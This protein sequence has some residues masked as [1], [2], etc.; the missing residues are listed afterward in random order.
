MKAWKLCILILGIG[1][2]VAPLHATAGEPPE[3]SPQE[4]PRIDK[5]VKAIV[6]G[7][8]PGSE[9]TVHWLSDD[10]VDVEIVGLEESGLG[11]FRSR[12]FLGVELSE[13]TPDLR[14]HFGAP[15]EAGVLVGRVVDD[16]PA[17]QAGVRVGD[18]ITAINGEPVGSGWDVR[19]L[20]GSLDEG[21][22]AI[23]ELVRDGGPLEVR[24]TIRERERAQVDVRHMMRRLPRVGG[25]GGA[26]PYVVHFE[27]EGF[28]K[29][30]EDL[31][32]RVESPEFRREVIDLRSR[33]S[34]LLERLEALE[35][36][37]GELETELESQPR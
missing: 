30:L 36:R 14:A 21:D 10:E 23:L 7:G 34:E 5:R 32:R 15:R 27:G 20:V 18:V 31:R 6:I 37:I 2:W 8:K 28:S 24:A 11:H 35:K 13:I 26:E 25:E 33:E 12:G 17:A 19:R 9:G 3:E 1:L 29:I 22:A 16:S 4:A